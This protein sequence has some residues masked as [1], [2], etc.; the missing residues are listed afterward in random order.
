M[1]GI[2]YSTNNLKIFKMKIKPFI[3]KTAYNIQGIE[4]RKLDESECYFRRREK[5][6]SILTFLWYKKQF[7]SRIFVT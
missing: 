3:F 6:V 5:L 7:F 4:P 1:K 2:E